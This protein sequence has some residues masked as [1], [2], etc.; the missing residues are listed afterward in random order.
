MIRRFRLVLLKKNEKDPDEKAKK[1]VDNLYKMLDFKNILE[2]VNRERKAKEYAAGKVKNAKKDVKATSKKD[3]E[4]YAANEF[5]E[6]EINEYKKKQKS[7]LLDQILGGINVKQ[8]TEDVGETA[9]SFEV[10]DLLNRMTESV[11]ADLGI[12]K[13]RRQDKKTLQFDDEGDK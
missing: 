9:A 5:T 4:K 10:Q 1:I 13:N 2:D 6:N 8:E 12:S 11:Y 7:N 3:A